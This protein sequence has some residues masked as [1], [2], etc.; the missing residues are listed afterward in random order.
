MSDISDD[1]PGPVLHWYDLICPFCY[2]GQSRTALLVE[3]GFEV[4][5]LPF[6]AHPDIPAAGLAVG[7]R[8]GPRSKMLEREAAAEGLVLHWP[9]RIPNSRNAL[10]AAE[11]VR[12]NQP[13]A[14]A[15]L[16]RKLFE[17]HFALGEDIGEL[18]VI[19]R[20]AAD[21]GVNLPT[22]HTAL[23]DGGAYAEVDQAERAGHRCGV[24]GTPAWL[25]GGRMV[26]GL[27]P[28]S[29]FELVARDA[30]GTR[31]LVERTHR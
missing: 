8:R 19:D 13:D 14:F 20:H 29:E 22:L 11:W 4:I 7:P 28:M 26:A 21:A 2:I 15:E 1:A 6:Q 18:A 10:A 27:L 24:Y 3:A 30:V 17:A 12:R 23:A 16:Q 25:L 9:T 5:S 31:A